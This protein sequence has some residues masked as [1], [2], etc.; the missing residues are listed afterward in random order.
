MNTNDL[1]QEILKAVEKGDIAQLYMLEQKANDLF[2]E[3]TLINYYKNILDL[4]LERL[5]DILEKHKKF[6]LEDVQDFATV[7]A[8]YEYAMEHYHAGKL[9]DAA[10]LFEILGGITNDKK[11]SYAM[12]IHALAA[13]AD[14][15]LDTFLEKYANM[16]QIEQNGT[17]YIGD[18]TKKVQDLL[19]DSEGN[20]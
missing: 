8:L 4:A 19:K 7:R 9:S 3:A 5:T 13:N 12:N 11:F 2:D 6:N 17:F 10:A 15:T 1:K 16:Q 20:K 18:F 14:I